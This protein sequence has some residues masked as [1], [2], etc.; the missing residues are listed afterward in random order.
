MVT[1]SAYVAPGTRLE[2]KD[3]FFYPRGRNI[4]QTAPPSVDRSP[5][6]ERRP[7]GTRIFSSFFFS[8]EAAEDCRTR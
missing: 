8:D 1:F 4:S 2:L 7:K 6:G 3:F 5:R